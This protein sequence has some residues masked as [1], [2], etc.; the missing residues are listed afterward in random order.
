MWNADAADDS[1]VPKVKSNN[2]TSHNAAFVMW[3]DPCRKLQL[4]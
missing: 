3:H 2:K 4:F 1:A